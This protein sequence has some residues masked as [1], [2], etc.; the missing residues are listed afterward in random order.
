MGFSTENVRRSCRARSM[1]TQIPKGLD[2]LRSDSCY[3]IFGCASGS[4]ECL[5]HLRDARRGANRLWRCR[6]VDKTFRASAV[7]CGLLAEGQHPTRKRP[8]HTAL[9]QG[10]ALPTPHT[11]TANLLKK[12]HPRTLMRVTTD[13]PGG[14]SRCL[15]RALPLY[16]WLF[17]CRQRPTRVALASPRSDLSCRRRCLGRINSAAKLPPCCEQLCVRTGHRP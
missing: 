5:E 11:A 2:C 4:L 15:R 8:C 16:V 12:E 14:L 13:R 7:P 9:G 6:T 1:R 10:F 3:D 17:D